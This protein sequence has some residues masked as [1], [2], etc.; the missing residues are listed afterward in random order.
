M[1]FIRRC[2]YTYKDN[3]SVENSIREERGKNNL[4]VPA[5][6]YITLPRSGFITA[7]RNKH[8][9]NSLGGAAIMAIETI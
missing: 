6:R 9:W 3:A 2:Y 4:S 5:S 8:K 7:R 1:G